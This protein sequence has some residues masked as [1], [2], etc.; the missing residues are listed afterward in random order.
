MTLLSRRAVRYTRAWL[1]GPVD[2]VEEETTLDRA[3]TSVPATLVRPRRAIGPQPGWVVLHGMTRP[4]RAHGQLVRFTRALIST[5]A[6]AIVP[7]VPEWRNLD[8]A[9]HLATP[10][11]KAG[12]GGLRASG[13]AH[14]A[15]VGVIG[16]SFGAPHAIASSADPYLANE[17]AGSVGFG[18]Y[19]DL[20]STFRFMMTGVHE[21]AGRG[22]GVL[23]D[24]YGRW[25]VGA[26]Y[27]TAVS[28]FTDCSDVADALR[29][30]AAYS[31]DLGESSWGPAY[32]PIIAILRERVAPE[33]RT[34]FD[35]FAP[36]AGA[37]PDTRAASDIAEGLA[38]AAR[39]ADPLIDPREM[40]ASVEQPVHILH[41]RGDRLIP[42]S[43]GAK[44]QEAL[45]A[46]TWSRLTITR[47]FGHAAQ[48]PF[49]SILR[50]LHEVPRFTRALTG[51]LAVT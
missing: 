30:L 28:G 12:L 5:G 50:A 40:L 44:L 48:D 35:L 10:T 19:C 22:P 45:P 51:M 7:E 26:N 15:P 21:S 27:L 43:E 25:I 23:P 34:T 49:P 32:D 4:G 9:P 37:M 46:T 16:F 33:R 11:V 47:L 39:Q 42:A 41:G 36:P 13:W 8:L 31:G 6:V 17:V 29:E 1:T 38:S 2:F 24:P 20:E 3:G 18:G 14:D